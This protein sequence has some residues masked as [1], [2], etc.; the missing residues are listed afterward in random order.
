MS[1][2]DRKQSPEQPEGRQLRP[3][4]ILCAALALLSAAL[5]VLLGTAKLSFELPNGETQV[6]YAVTGR[7][8]AAPDA[9]VYEGYTFLGWQSGDG[10]IA[11]VDSVTAFGSRSYS[12]V[13][14]VALNETEHVQYLFPD[15]YG[16]YHPYDELTRAEAARMLYALLA[17]PVEGTGN[18]ADVDADSVYAE[19]TAALY[20]LQVSDAVSFYPEQPIRLGELLS[21]LAHFYPQTQA[22][23]EI[24][25]VSAQNSAYPA[26]CLAL[27]KGWVELDA[28]GSLDAGRTLSR[29]EACR[30]M[31]TL[32]HRRADESAL[33]ELTG[34]IPDMP[35]DAEGFSEVAEAA[36]THEY[37]REGEKEIY[38]SIPEFD[39]LEP[40]FF[41]IGTA[42]YC[43]GE[44]GVALTDTD[45]GNLHFGEDGRYTSQD[46]Q[47]D[48]LVNGVLEKRLDSS[49]D[50]LERLR[51][52]YDYTVTSFEYQ[53]QNALRIGSEGW[54][55]DEAYKMLST[56]RGNCYSYAAVFCMLARAVGFDA[57]TRAGTLDF[58]GSAHGWVEIEID[59]EW[60]YFDPE[61]EMTCLYNRGEKVDRFMFDDTDTLGW[62]YEVKW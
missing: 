51:A 35:V 61:L 59:G 15:E 48:A 18:Y 30:L 24:A 2:E 10:E 53:R 14:T 21:M 58:I 7:S 32:L 4:W 34:L 23:Y 40:G 62:T 33:P 26:Y 27:E 50:P 25:D 5:F 6:R 55:Q 46:I 16:F 49:M 54:E 20:Y 45:V 22:R 38:A 42:L 17:V 11:G 8:V 19:A 47:L 52:V 9:P 28:Q 13:Y 43:I 36:L 1:E 39:R 37:R 41:Q 60:Y 44:D 29:I 12:P 31:N 3:A 57:E 56:G